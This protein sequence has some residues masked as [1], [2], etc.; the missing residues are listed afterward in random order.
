MAELLHSSIWAV[1]AQ[2][3][4]LQVSVRLSRHGFLDYGIALSEVHSYIAALS[5]S[6]KRNKLSASGQLAT[7]ASQKCR[8]VSEL[9]ELANLHSVH[10]LY[11]L[12]SLMNFVIGLLKI[13]QLISCLPFKRLSLYK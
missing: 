10:N 1:T 7:Y 8:V 9:F 4:N 13:L 5:I 2:I 11:C 12:D 3:A 6:F